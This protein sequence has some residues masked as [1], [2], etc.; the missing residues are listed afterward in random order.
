MQTN[1]RHCQ[2]NHRGLNITITSATNTTPFTTSPLPPRP[3]CIQ[4]TTLLSFLTPSE[5]GRIFTLSLWY[6]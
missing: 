2:T 1:H 3:H 4:A 6:D 5:L